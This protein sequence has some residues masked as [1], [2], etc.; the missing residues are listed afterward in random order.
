MERDFAAI[1]LRIEANPLGR[2]MH[3]QRELFHSNLIAWF[4]DELPEA[5][6]AVF[7]PLADGGDDRGRSVD[8]EGNNL[9]LVFHWPDRAPLVVENKVFALPNREQLESYSRAVRSWSAAPSLVLLSV[10]PP[11]FVPHGWTHLSYMELAE[12]ITEALP[13]HN[14][15]EVETMRRYAALIADLHEL[16]AMTDVTSDDEP[17]WLPPA[18]LDAL[19]SK[20]M[21]GALHKARAQ[22]VAAALN[23]LIPGLDPVAK[24]DLSNATPLVEVLERTR[25]DDKELLVGWQLQGDQFRRALV[26]WG[27]GYEG[28]TDQ[29]KARREEFARRHPQL[30][31]FP[32][33]LAQEHA[34]RK[35]FNHFAPTFVYRYV[36]AP[37]LTI[38]ELK[39]AALEL[40]ATIGKEAVERSH[41]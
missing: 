36:K 10:S 29:T 16:V 6:D 3:G 35:E 8:R 1:A 37:G 19:S 15:Y 28:R 7:R 31:A 20:Q 32:A 14:S 38:G 2:L 39:V 24:G 21:R 25:I 9:D 18:A 23:E 27:R 34:G 22:R 40:H 11:D 26:L 33:V 4:F 41:D 12:M 5:A 17:V 13:A 30:F